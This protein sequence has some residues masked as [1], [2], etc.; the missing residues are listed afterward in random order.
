M[1]NLYLLRI[2]SY[3]ERIIL[4]NIDFTFTKSLLLAIHLKDLVS[5]DAVLSDYTADQKINFQKM[6]QLS[7]ILSELMSGQKYFPNIKVNA[8][9]I[10]IMKVCTSKHSCNIGNMVKLL[11]HVRIRLRNFGNLCY[12]FP[13]DLLQLSLEPR[14]NENEIYELSLAREPRASKTAGSVVSLWIG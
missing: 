4:A 11:Q 12:S 5:L 10:D 7:S 8:E 9:T 13:Y 14:F 1:I 2:L 3:C 6:M